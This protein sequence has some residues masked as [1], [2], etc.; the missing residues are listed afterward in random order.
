MGLRVRS[1]WLLACGSEQCF[2]FRIYDVFHKASIIATSCRTDCSED[3]RKEQKAGGGRSSW[4]PYI[5]SSHGSFR[6]F[7]LVAN[8]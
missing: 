2:T 5:I 4:S 6:N 3:E 7:E 8:V 1:E